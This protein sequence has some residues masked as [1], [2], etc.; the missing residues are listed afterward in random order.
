MNCL[1]EYKL[2]FRNFCD[3]YDIRPD[4]V[5]YLCFLEAVVTL[6]QKSP[7]IDITELYSLFME[8]KNGSID[9]KEHTPTDEPEWVQLTFWDLLD[10]K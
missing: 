6:Q 10:D 8:L 3:R 1:D 4:K 2:L 5:N 7:S 9:M